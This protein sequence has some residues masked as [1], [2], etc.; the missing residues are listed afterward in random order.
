MLLRTSRS[1]EG[2]AVSFLA[3]TELGIAPDGGLFVPAED[4][5]LSPPPAALAM[6]F[7]AT[8]AW[9]LRDFLKG[10]VEPAQLDR[11]IQA[12]FDFPVQLE[13]HP[14]GPALLDLTQGPTRAFK[15]VGARFL[16]ALW[17]LNPTDGGRT[18]L[19]ATSGDTGGAVADA[20]AGLPGIRV[21]VLFPEGQVSPIQR[22]QFTTLQGNVS[23][24]AV[25]GPFDRCQAEVKRAFADPS[26]AGRHRLTSAN[27]INIGRLLP[28][29]LPYLHLSRVT[30]WNSERPAGR[31]GTLIIPSGNLGNV[32]GAMM[33]RRAGAPIGR[34]V[35]A[36]N[37]NDTLVRWLADRT[38][39][40]Q[41][42]VPTP[43][44]AMDVGR[45]SN[46][47]RVA[48]LMAAGDALEAMSVTDDQTLA[49]IRRA[50][51][52]GRPVDPHTAVGMVVAE[53]LVAEGTDPRTITVVETASPAKFPE[54]MERAGVT[55]PTDPLLERNAERAEHTWSLSQ[56][57]HLS[58][59]LDQILSAEAGQ[60]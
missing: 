17:A 33:A 46:L 58:E 8:A 16:A 53:R 3:A 41:A 6:D 2:A 18:V 44:S 10:E 23:A 27:S 34:I 31:P 59:L 57:D 5:V 11:L 14:S 35:A 50:A 56:T 52:S 30:G 9:A 42:S 32:W 48:G 7:R 24:V 19:V 4:L 45:P 36:C 21:I 54:V 26:L 29:V 1:A 13:R 47:E 20:C 15:D 55:A 40:E 22:R 60:P 37:R 28:Q 39:T 38:F 12:A 25:E 51:D 43:S 49:A